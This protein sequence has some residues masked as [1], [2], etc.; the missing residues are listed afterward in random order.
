VTVSGEARQAETPRYPLRSPYG[1]VGDP[2]MTRFE[3]A[4]A[5]DLWAKLVVKKPARH[6]GIRDLI[7]LPTGW[8]TPWILGKFIRAV[9]GDRY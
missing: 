4:I 6:A 7:A 2:S 3:I 9:V 1:F 8:Y 5:V